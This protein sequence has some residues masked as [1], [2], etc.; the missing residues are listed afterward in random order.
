[1]KFNSNPNHGVSTEAQVSIPSLVIIPLEIRYRIYVAIL[2]SCHDIYIKCKE[3]WPKKHLYAGALASLLQ[4]S[5]QIQLEINLWFAN[6]FWSIK[7]RNGWQCGEE[8]PDYGIMD[9]YA[10]T[11]FRG[12]GKLYRI[13][14]MSGQVYIMQF[15]GRRVK[16]TSLREGRYRRKLGQVLDG[17]WHPSKLLL[18]EDLL[19]PLEG[20]SSPRA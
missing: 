19:L 10:T 12:N 1:M 20:L 7:K 5:P 8:E 18:L 9:N 11:L 6:L 4:S 14:L 17:F 3:S 2:S 15:F 13:N 16:Y